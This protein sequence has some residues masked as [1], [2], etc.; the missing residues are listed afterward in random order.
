MSLNKNT[1]QTTPVSSTQ[2]P[3]S[4]FS[5]KASSL[6]TSVTRSLNDVVND[7]ERGVRKTSDE[8]SKAWINA[9]DQV[10]LCKK[11]KTT[12]LTRNFFSVLDRL[13]SFLLKSSS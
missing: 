1:T 2:P 12:M 3:S 5:T 7:L 10:C 4:S 6:F 9:T 11:K 8:M 13:S